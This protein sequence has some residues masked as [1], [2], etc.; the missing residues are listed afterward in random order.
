MRV[1]SF[2]RHRS[3]SSRCESCR[4]RRTFLESWHS[5]ASRRSSPSYWSGG[6]LCLADF[7]SKV[8]GSKNS[9]RVQSHSYPTLALRFN[10][11]RPQTQTCLITYLIA[12]DT[13]DDFI[14]PIVESKLSVLN[15][16]GL[17]KDCFAGAMLEVSSRHIAPS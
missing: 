6:L 8:H 14:W 12:R 3:H 5:D 10:P 15:K 4:F 2:V 7:R 17:S 1:V 16:A 13:A 9:Y 11:S